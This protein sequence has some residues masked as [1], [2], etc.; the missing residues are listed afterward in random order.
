MRVNA[1]ESNA[2]RR[3]WAACFMCCTLAS[4]ALP[5]QQKSVVVL[6]PE[7]V[8]DGTSDQAASGWVV[9]VRGDRIESVGLPTSLRIPSDATI[10]DLPRV[11]L[12]P[13]LIDAHS[14][15]LL[16]PYNETS[17]DDQVLRES[18]ALR[19]TRATVH[20]RQ[21]LASGWIL[22]RDLGTE[23]AGYADV[24]LKEAIDAGI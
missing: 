13:G 2:G 10:I 24:G 18:L 19:T 20:A 3:S 8:W 17:W 23:G 4:T 6:R 12:L 14:H 16:H 22:L 7:R 5:A 11:T 21:T 1:R 15:L 9:L